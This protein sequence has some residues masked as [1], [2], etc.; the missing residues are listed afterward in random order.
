MINVSKRNM[1]LI[2]IFGSGTIIGACLIVVLPESCGLLIN[3]SYQLAKLEHPDE[4][5]DVTPPSVI[6]TIGVTIILGFTLM[7]VID[8]GFKIIGEYRA[9][10]RKKDRLALASGE[11]DHTEV[12]QDPYKSLNNETEPLLQQRALSEHDHF[13]LE[14]GLIT[15][16]AIALHSLIEGV[17][18]AASL[19]LSTSG[20]NKQVGLIVTFALF[21]HKAPEAAGL[22]TFLVHCEPSF[23]TRL[24]YILI[25]SGCSPL[26]AFI[27]FLCFNA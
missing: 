14:A 18:M 3:A 15:T 5:P 16:I 11:D 12:A 17:A 2:S 26:T 13:H 19:Y 9:E 7:L 1:N 20:A 8:E 21:L 6:S 10:R 23:A 4:E 22:G 24:T 27:G 25:Y